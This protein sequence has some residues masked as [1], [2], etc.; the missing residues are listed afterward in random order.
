MSIL[1]SK[2]LYEMGHYFLDTQYLQGIAS[3]RFEFVAMILC[4]E[5]NDYLLY[6]V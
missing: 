2:L 6:I 3:N 1:Y 4:I 5:L